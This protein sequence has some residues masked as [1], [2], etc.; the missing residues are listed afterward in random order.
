M[1]CFYKAINMSPVL[2]FSKSKEE[3]DFN[4]QEINLFDSWV[5]LFDKVEK[6]DLNFVKKVLLECYKEGYHSCAVIDT[7]YFNEIFQLQKTFTERVFKLNFSLKTAL[8]HHLDDESYIGAITGGGTSNFYLDSL[9]R[10]QLQY[11]DFKR[12]LPFAK[13]IAETINS[14]GPLSTIEKIV[15][16]DNWFQQNIQFII[17]KKSQGPNGEIYICKEIKDVAI[18]PDVFEKHYGKC[19]DIAV[20]LVAILHYLS[21]PADVICANN[22]AWVIIAFDNKHYIWDCTFNITRNPNRA[23]NALKAFSYSDRYTLIGSNDFEHKVHTNINYGPQ[24]GKESYPRC[25]IVHA[26]EKLQAL[27][28]D[29]EYPKTILYNSIKESKS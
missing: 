13:S 27:G 9:N 24:V 5:V 14:I 22:H 11:K 4:L 12:I 15:A 29:F 17:D 26:I 20:S 16:V 18:V 10:N 19:E 1:K 6:E 3:V 21:I 2:F 25:Q 7:L 23:E 8:E 28:V